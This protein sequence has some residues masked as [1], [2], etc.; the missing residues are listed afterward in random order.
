V[1][2]RTNARYV[3]PTGRSLL[4]TKCLEMMHAHSKGQAYKYDNFP[5]Y[6]TAIAAADQNTMVITFATEG[7]HLGESETLT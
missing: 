5:V 2:T 6:R 7:G 3:M 4:T 1:R